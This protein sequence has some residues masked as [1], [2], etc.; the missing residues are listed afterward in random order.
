MPTGRE[1]V[2]ENSILLKTS[3]WLHRKSLECKTKAEVLEG[4][5]WALQPNPQ[6]ALSGSAVELGV[7]SFHLGSS[8]GKSLELLL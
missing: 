1:E 8:F 5:L 3:H 4:E 7:A 6:V 2:G